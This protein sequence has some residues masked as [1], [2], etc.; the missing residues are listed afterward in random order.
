M[1]FSEFVNKLYTYCGNGQI[2]P[3]FLQELLKKITSEQ[4]DVIFEKE[5]SEYRKYFNGNRN[6]PKKSAT[7]ILSHLDKECFDSYLYN[8]FSDDSLIQLCK[9]FED[10]IGNATSENVTEKLTDLFISILKNIAIKKQPENK[11]QNAFMSDQDIEKSLAQIV[12]SLSNIT[13]EE[14]DSI[15]GY[16]PVNVDKKIL[17]QNALLKDEIRNKV[18]KFY[19]YIENLFKEAS[20]N[21]SSFFDN[22]ANA[23][24]FASDNYINQN[25]PQ[26]VVYNYMVQWFKNKS[27]SADDTACRI[28]VAFFVQ[29]CEVFHEISE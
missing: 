15:I 14:I 25:L 29:N 8:S 13:Q 18:V 20:N 7:Y 17:P 1:T 23:V 4:K 3:I 12:N 10:E 26:Q 24:K 22:L 6:L 5:E 2:A 28:M 9:E 16:E 11:S 27:Y 21:N 19:L